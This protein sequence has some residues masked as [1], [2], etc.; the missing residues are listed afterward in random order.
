VGFKFL[1]DRP[2]PAKNLPLTNVQWGLYMTNDGKSSE[3]KIWKA[4]VDVYRD[5]M[6]I[7]S[8]DLTGANEI[9]M[10]LAEHRRDHIVLNRIPQV[11]RID[12][13][14]R[15]HANLVVNCNS[16]EL[17]AEDAYHVVYKTLEGNPLL[18]E[19]LIYKKIDSTVRGNLAAEIEAVLDLDMADLIFF[20]PASPLMGRTTVGGYH[21]VNGLPITRTEYVSGIQIKGTSYLPEL[22]DPKTKYRCRPATIGVLE[23]GYRR[24]AKF[25]ESCYREGFRTIVFDACSQTDLRVICR[26]IAGKPLRI[27]AVGSTALFEAVFDVQRPAD[28]GQ[29]LVVCASLNHQS[30]LQ[31]RLLVRDAGAELVLVDLDAGLSDPQRE[32]QRVI[33]LAQAHF[34]AGRDLIL[35]TPEEVLTSEPGFRPMSREGESEIDRFLGVLTK[36]LLELHPPAGLILIGGGL[37][38]QVI[39]ALGGLGIEITGR[40]ASFVPIGRLSG[41]PFDGLTLITKGGGVGDAEILIRAVSVLRRRFASRHQ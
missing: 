39:N 7:I 40:L 32:I 16:R 12:D 5:P 21:L 2:I 10:V 3:P 26:A 24:V 17:S 22:I 27:L 4:M 38:T 15:N 23:S 37:A 31:T 8:D 28:A 11:Q 18:R 33:P 19:R 36:R 20:A 35:A 29:C 41:G 14:F 9:G 1:K 13:L 34:Q 30:R 6:S 25:A